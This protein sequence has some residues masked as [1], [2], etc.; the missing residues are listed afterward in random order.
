M[1]NQLANLC[2]F[3]ALGGV[4]ISLGTTLPAL[5]ATA[6]L[7][8]SSGSF[9]TVDTTTGIFTQIGTTPQFFDIA[10]ANSTLGYGV[11]GLGE[12]Y[13]INL[14]N[15]STTLIGNTGVSVNG[16]GFDDSGNLF[17]TGTSSFYSIDL[18]TGAASQIAS[19]SGFSSAGDIAF[20][21]GQFFA[22]SS[23]G[24]L[25]SFNADGTNQTNIGAIGFGDV[26]GLTYS[27]G[28]LF[29]YTASGDILTI[30]MTTGAGIDIGN[31]IGLSGRIYGS[32]PTSESVPEPTS[33]LGAAAAFGLAGLLRKKKNQS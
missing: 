25:F 10:V 6:Y 5:G 11:T 26:W 17:A 20:D 33:I 28:E 7:G 12:L 16:L 31:V 4:G 3:T 29:G 2:I 32:A 13:S 24:N 30:D 23:S 1:K 14:A 22:T 9:G 8:S 18:G 19:I 21:G 27:Q 15:A